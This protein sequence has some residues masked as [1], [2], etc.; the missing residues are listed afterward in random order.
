ML[1]TIYLGSFDQSQKEPMLHSTAAVSKL[2]Q[3]IVSMIK[4]GFV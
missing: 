4:I 3:K 2:L 1:L